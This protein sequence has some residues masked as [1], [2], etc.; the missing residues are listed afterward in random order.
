MVEFYAFELKAKV[1]KVVRES[2]R[3]WCGNVP[4]YCKAVE[5]V[6][7]LCRSG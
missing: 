5:A 7:E 4:P 2:F 1:C 6:V 3:C